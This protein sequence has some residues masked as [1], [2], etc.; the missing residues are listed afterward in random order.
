MNTMYPA[1]LYVHHSVPRGHILYTYVVNHR[2]MEAG[3][4]FAC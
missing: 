3:R 4:G 1:D 2:A